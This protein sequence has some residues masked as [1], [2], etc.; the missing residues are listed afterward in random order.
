M[1]KLAPVFVI[2]IIT[3]FLAGGASRPAYLLTTSAE[4]ILATTSSLYDSGLLDQLLSAFEKQSGIKVKPIAVGTGEALK[5]GQ[6]GEADILLVHAPELEN[7]FMSLG[8]GLR[9]EELLTSGFILLGPANDPA[10]VQGLSFPQALTRIAQSK[11]FFVSRGDNSGTHFLERK[12]WEEVGLKPVG[13][14]YLQ[15][16]Q[17][18]AETLFIASEKQAYLLADYPAYARLRT[19]LKLKVL[20]RDENYPNI[21]S[22]IL[23]KT[24]NNQSQRE[25]AERLVEFLLSPE[26]KRIIGAFGQENNEMEGLF[27]LIPPKRK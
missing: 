12:L 14:W 5:M 27:R 1:S 20:C 13:K 15:T 19:V 26:A 9:R 18:M 3:N 24:R 11:A 10:R 17:G 4:I 7:Q 23:V 8:Y 2:L 16:G 22:V 21:Y 25:A 6:K